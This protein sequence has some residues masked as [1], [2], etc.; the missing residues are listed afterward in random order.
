MKKSLLKLAIFLLIYITHND[1]LLLAYLQKRMLSS[2]GRASPLHGGGRGFEPLSIHQNIRKLPFGRVAKWLNAADCKSVT[3]GFG[4]S[5]L[6][7][8]T[9]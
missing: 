2:A 4:S 1:I 9:T 7:P 3:S 8:P 6:P 5:N